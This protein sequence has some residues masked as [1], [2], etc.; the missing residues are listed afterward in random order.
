MTRQ[1]VLFVTPECE[2]LIKVGGL[3]DIS[4]SLPR[5]MI[6]RGHD[7]RLL[8][9]LYRG[10]GT[11]LRRRATVRA[12]L[13]DGG[14]LREWRDGPVPV[15]LL[16][17]PGFAR[18]EHPYHRRDGS[19]WPGDAMDCNALARAAAWLAGGRAGLDW[20][21]DIVHCNDWMTGLVPVWMQLERI[22][23]ASI[24]TIHNL[25]HQGLFASSELADAGL[26]AWLFHPE[27]LEYFGRWSLIKG[28]LNFAD[29]LTTVS[30][31]YAR[32]IQTAAVGEGLDGVLR[33]RRKALTG[34]LNGIESSAWNPRHDAALAASFYPGSLKGKQLCT[35][36]LRHE[37]GLESDP[38]VPL[39]AFVGR[40]VGQKGAELLLAALPQLF[41]EPLQLA[42][43]GVGDPALEAEFRR[44]A[45]AYSDRLVYVP[46]YDPALAR[47]VYAGAEL[48]LMPSR[49]E[50]CGLAQMYAMR[51]GTVPV[52]HAV[53]GL[54]DTILPLATPAGPAGEAS[55]FLF[56][57]YTD[58]A[59]VAA[60]AGARTAR[61]DTKLWHDLMR[62]GMRRRFDWSERAA[63]YEQVYLEAR[64]V[65]QRG[66]EA[67]RQ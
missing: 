65:L 38:T 35:A 17:T 33:R 1:R 43:V 57:A 66:S 39:A 11:D 51:Y 2:G 44:A 50:P 21:A 60:V 59:L 22:A 48:F 37:L 4:A 25:A 52:A 34:I 26:P 32:E 19:P 8:L 36:A 18:R 42:V 61:R 6:R 40:L 14:L 45:A 46:R 53:G 56:S 7:V 9:P 63:E 10:L 3:A 67:P 58:D 23:A 30:P 24:F 54:R 62:N 41:V 12:R 47:R 5:A 29:R 16:D 13:P 55:G 15:W 27:A 28:G 49:F 64:R 20:H 31:T